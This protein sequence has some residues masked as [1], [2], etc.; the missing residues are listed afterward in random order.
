MTE[1]SSRRE[2]RVA[3][4]LA[5]AREVVEAIAAVVA[6]VVAAVEASFSA[7]ELTI[8]ILKLTWPVSFAS[9]TV[10]F[11]LFFT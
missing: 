9:W 1:F 2:V 4:G 11:E 3:A 10:N 6:G 5:E 8:L 7:N